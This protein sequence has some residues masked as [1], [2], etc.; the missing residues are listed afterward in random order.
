[1]IERQSF[2]FTREPQAVRTARGALDAV[3]DRLPA[4]K[5]YDASLCL[6]ELVTNAIQHSP[7][8]DD[9]E[10]LLTVELGDRALRVEVM[11]PGRSFEPGQPT[12]GDERGWGLF[13]VDR[14][15]TRWGVDRAERTTVWFEIDV[16]AE[17]TT[18]A[19]A[20]DAAMPGRSERD[21]RLL[22]AAALRRAARLA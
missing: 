20:G 16:G 3:Q 14:L 18:T 2:T 6:S 13:I 5:A 8:V 9:E 17:G 12:Q 1:L 22:R 7:S 19:E 15:A 10:L 21:D 11:D 4:G